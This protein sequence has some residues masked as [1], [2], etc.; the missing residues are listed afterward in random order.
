MDEP[1]GATPE[2][3]QSDAIS[4]PAPE[5]IASA[6]DQ[7]QPE[8]PSDEPAEMSLEDL[9]GDDEEEEEKP[10]GD[11]QITEDEAVSMDRR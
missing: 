3:S 9:F 4:E 2:E 7:G 8:P 1:A 6:A 11:D 10:F 5:D